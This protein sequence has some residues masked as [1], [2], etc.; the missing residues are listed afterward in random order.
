[1]SQLES[2][3]LGPLSTNLWFAVFDFNDDA[4][5]GDNWRLLTESEEDPVWSPLTSNS[6][7]LTVS[8]IPRV[9]A[10]S[11]PIPSEEEAKAKAGS[12]MKSFA[13]GTTQEEAENAMQADVVED[14][15]D[16]NSFEESVDASVD[17]GE[18]SMHDKAP[19]QEPV[20]E[21]SPNKEVE[22]AVVDVEAPKV[23]TGK[24]DKDEDSFDNSFDDEDEE[25]LEISEEE[26]E[27]SIEESQEV[28]K[29]LAAQEEAPVES[30]PS[31]TPGTITASNDT[32]GKETEPEGSMRS[33][34]L[35]TIRKKRKKRKKS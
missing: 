12:G 26:L 35:G 32:L 15:D 31:P 34:A 10:G 33:F 11:I 1:L 29:P 23:E 9:Q 2:A 5:T 28:D 16:A 3:H 19:T 30:T 4:K 22:N 25:E 27:E 6:E 21:A 18:V 17:E 7:A 13:L 14:G 8:T 24:Q 20:T